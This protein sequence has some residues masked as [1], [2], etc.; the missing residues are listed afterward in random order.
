[1]KKL[2]FSLFGIF[3]LLALPLQAIEMDMSI[4]N[5]MSKEISKDLNVPTIV[6]PDEREEITGKASESEQAAVV[7]VI[8][9][10]SGH[11]NSCSGVMLG[12]RI[13]LTAAHCINKEGKY[14]IGAQVFA[15]GVSES[16]ILYE[17]KKIDVKSWVYDEESNN[18]IFCISKKILGTK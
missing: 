2:I 15:V 9:H 13:V 5:D 7:I 12:P 17:K 1:M 6:G 10:K 18:S 3:I 8:A 4:L 14:P 16:E 11:T